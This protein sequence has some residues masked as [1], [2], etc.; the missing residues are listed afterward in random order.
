MKQPSKIEDIELFF[1]LT[2]LLR[3]MSAWKTA[4]SKHSSEKNEKV[5]LWDYHFL[6]PYFLSA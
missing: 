3:A 6:E 2:F 4:R 1:S 5:E